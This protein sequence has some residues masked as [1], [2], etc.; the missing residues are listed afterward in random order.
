MLLRPSKKLLAKWNK[1]LRESGFVDVERPDGL[2]VD[3][4]REALL[5]KRPNVVVQATREYYDIAAAFTYEH[6][7]Q[8]V[9]DRRIWELH[10]QGLS[11]LK[12]GKLVRRCASVVKL[13]LR[14]LQALAGLRR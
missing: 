13:R 6:T 8:S 9:L 1:K 3:Y 4:H 11:A 2:F 14:R 5:K 7:W 10:V 12:I